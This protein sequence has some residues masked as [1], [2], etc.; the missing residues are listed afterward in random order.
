MAK[1]QPPIKVHFVTGTRAEFGLMRQTLHVLAA[2]PRFRLKVIATGMHLSAR[3][4]KTVDEVRRAGLGQVQVV[5]WAGATSLGVATGRAMAGFARIF[6][7]DR[8][9][10]VLLVGDRVEPFAAAA[11]AH[12]CGVRVAHVH[13]GDR[14]LGQVDDSLRHAITKLSHLHLAA[15][16]TSSQRLLRL[17]E[18]VRY[19]K[20]VGP[21][22]LESARSEAA[23]VA[24]VRAHCGDVSAAALL[25]YHPV[26]AD[27]QVEGTIARQIMG[28]IDEQPAIKRIIL[29]GPNSDPGH[30]GVRDAMRAA[31]FAD[32]HRH[33]FYAHVTRPLFLGLLRD[34]R[35]LVGNSS[36]GLIETLAFERPTPTLNVGTRQTG[37]ECGLN[38]IHCGPT[39]TEVRSGLRRV[40]KV[41]RTGRGITTLPTAK[42]IC[43]ALSNRRLPPQHK[44]ICY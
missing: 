38:V 9:D 18:D 36:A 43:D 16:R 27:R 4:G 35:V 1:R 6:E 5:R 15:Y 30:E 14:A 24:E 2:D 13:G 25:L 39:A 19:V 12:L 21:P 42:L 32:R 33:C 7:A 41:G 22:G 31:C 40:L 23:G 37:R 11:A 17:G 29:L 8:P 20:L 26:T 3:H 28:C 44:L 34:C 10:W